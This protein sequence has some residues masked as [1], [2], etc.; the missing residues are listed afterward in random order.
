MDQNMVKHAAI[1]GEST[2]DALIKNGFQAEFFPDKDSVK[3]RL[4]ELI[5]DGAG[6]GYGGSMTVRSLELQDEL[7][8]RGCRIYD[9]NLAA[10]PEEADEIRRS[11]LTSDVFLCSSNAITRDGR[12]YNVDGAGN[13][14]AAMIYGPKEVIVV[15]G[16]NKVVADL[17]E[18]EVRVYGI[19]GPINNIRLNT[20]NP[21]TK[22]GECMDCASPRRICNIA[23]ILHRRPSRTAFRVLLVGEAMGY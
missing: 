23:V 11:Q 14:V 21:C 18:A 20:D 17:E 2:V 12:L 10:N 5:P 13:R 3:K 15:A 1:V 4:L 22:T 16:I 9:H 7:I 6:V 8:Q 19:A